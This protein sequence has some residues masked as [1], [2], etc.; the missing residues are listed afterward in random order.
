ML[1]GALDAPQ[2]AAIA[3]LLLGAWLLRARQ[4]PAQKEVVDLEA[5]HD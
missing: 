2:V 4:S 1:H 5:A 3:L